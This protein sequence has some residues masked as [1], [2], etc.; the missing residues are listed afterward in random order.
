MPAFL[1]LT[2]R[3]LLGAVVL[4]FFLLRVV[5]RMGPA[6]P[7]NEMTNSAANALFHVGT[8][9]SN[10]AVLLS[11][12]L[13][14]AFAVTGLRR[15]D[16][17]FRLRG[18]IAVCAISLVLASLFWPTSGARF[19]GPGVLFG[20][21]IA[22]F[23]VIAFIFATA[24]Q[25]GRPLALLLTL[26][27]LYAAAAYHYL[28][29][30]GGSIGLSLGGTT[31]ALTVAEALAVAVAPVAFFALRP[32]RNARAAVIATILTIVLAGAYARGAWM[33]SALAIWDLGFTGFLPPFVY[34]LA[35]WLFLYTTVAL[36][37]QR[38]REQQAL[39]LALIALAGI[40]L[41]YSYFNLLALSGYALLAWA[42]PQA[43]AQE[44][45]A[46]ESKAPVRAQ[47]G[48]MA[49][50]LRPQGRRVSL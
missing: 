23:A 31:E 34:L 11:I 12:A 2:G 36:F 40:K 35:F 30:A 20:L 19:T 17:L 37:H 45:A 24:G 1:A 14:T 32:G 25:R 38:S 22:S 33:V 29:R 27:A 50:L 4:E 41:D 7:Q 15:N 46:V 26:L 48:A 3:V 9:S 28:S 47:A 8:W 43:R 13:L 18:L 21:V 49:S 5:L 42:A 6:F 16:G 44:Q 39:G 10:L